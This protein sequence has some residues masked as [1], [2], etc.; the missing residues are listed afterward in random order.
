VPDP[1]GR[2]PVAGKSAAWLLEAAL[3]WLKRGLI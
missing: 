3:F 1:A 2:L